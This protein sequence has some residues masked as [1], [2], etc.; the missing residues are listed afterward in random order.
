MFPV[1]DDS[2]E[3]VHLDFHVLHGPDGNFPVQSH[4]VRGPEDSDLVFL[5][6]NVWYEYVIMVISQRLF[7]VDFRKWMV[8]IRVYVDYA[9]LLV[10][11]YE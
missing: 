3:T 4:G 5:S 11:Y 8:D 2:L 9:G 10:C 6:I 1:A 7:A